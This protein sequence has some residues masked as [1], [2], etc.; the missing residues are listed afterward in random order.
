MNIIGI[1]IDICENKRIAKLVDKFGNF[2]LKR[3]FHENEIIHGFKK[4]KNNKLM[5]SN[6]FAKRF[7]GKEAF[8]KACGFSKNIRKNEISILSNKNG[9][10]VIEIFGMTKQEIESH[11]SSQIFFHISL[12]DEK[13]FSIANVIIE[14]L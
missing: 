2:F 14:R 4:Y 5:L 7:A 1:G 11:F 6:F 13:D 10:P 9:K 8:T 3:I 12:S